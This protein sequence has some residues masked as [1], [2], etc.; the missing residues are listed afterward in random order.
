LQVSAG[1]NHLLP[2]IFPENFTVVS[3]GIVIIVVT[4]VLVV[5]VLVL[6]VIAL[7]AVAAIVLKY[8]LLVSRTSPSSSPGNLNVIQIVVAMILSISPFEN[9]YIHM[10]PEIFILIFFVS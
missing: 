8:C 4:V 7:L 10:L 5:V 9:L 1:A 6:T 2:S 3:L